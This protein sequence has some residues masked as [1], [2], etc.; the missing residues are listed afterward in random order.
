MAQALDHGQRPIEI[1][2]LHDYA[3]VSKTE[4]LASVSSVAIY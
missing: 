2:D 4:Q 1:I 3:L